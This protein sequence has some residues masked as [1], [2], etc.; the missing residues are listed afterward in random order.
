[1]RSLIEKMP[2]LWLS[3]SWTTREQRPG[4]SS[5]A[6]VFVS[7]EKF[8]QHLAE[9]GFLEHA[10]F[11]GNYYGTPVPDP[12][13]G[14]DVLLEIEVQGARQVRALDADAVLILLEAPSFEHQLERLRGRG[15]PEEKVQQRLAKG[16]EEVEAATELDAHRVVNDTVDNAVV[17]IQKLIE[18]ARKASVVVDGE[19]ERAPLLHQQQTQ[20]QQ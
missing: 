18:T 19:G 10:E 2:D 6:Y 7:R 13:P 20:V 11:L 16:T 15:D 3:R 8:E 5:D 1:M 4:E 12:P 9:D 14:C 17:E